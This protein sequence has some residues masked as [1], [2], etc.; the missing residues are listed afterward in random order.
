MPFPTR[1]G[2]LL[3]LGTVASN[4]FASIPI[5]RINAINEQL[6]LGQYQA[7]E[8]AALALLDSQQLATDDVSTL[9][10]LAGRFTTAGLRD[11]AGTLLT[12]AA[13]LLDAPQTSSDRETLL[14]IGASLQALNLRSQ[15][16]GVLSRGIRITGKDSADRLNAAGFQS[17]G[18]LAFET[19]DLEAADSAYTNSE[20]ALQ[21]DDLQARA[22]LVVRQIKLAVARA[23]AAQTMQR[24]KAYQ[25]LLT[26]LTGDLSLARMNLNVAASL[27]A[28]DEPAWAADI[29]LLIEQAAALAATDGQ[30]MSEIEQMRG[31]VAALVGQPDAALVMLRRALAGLGSDAMPAQTYRLYWQIGKLQAEAGEIDA[32]LINYERA[33]ANLDRIR[34]ELLQGS[35]LVFTER[36]LPVYQGY[37]ELLLEKARVPGQ[38]S[39]WLGQVQETLEGLNAA[40]ILD[41]FDDNCV[42]P[43][44]VMSLSNTAAG[45]AVLYPI[46]LGTRPV[47]LVRTANGIFRFDLDVDNAQLKTMALAFREAITNPKTSLAAYQAQA[48]ALFTALLGPAQG[49]IERSSI[50]TL[51]TVPSAYL[52]LVPMAALHDGEDFLVNRYQLATTLGLQLTEN[53]SIDNVNSSAF[54]GGVSDAVQ[55]FVSL[56]GVETELAE[57]KDALSATPLLNRN[58][59]VAN[60]SSRLSSGNDSIVHLATHGYFDGDHANSFLLAHDDKITLD[61]LQSTVGARRFTGNPLDLLVLSACETAKGDERAALGLAGVSLKAG[62]RST[63]ASLW[64]IADAATAMLMKRFY[65]ELRAG[66]SKA[67]ALQSAQQMLLSDPEWAHPNYW[68]PYLLIGNWL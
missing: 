40:E 37:I 30:V 67:A 23:D 62:A 33:I 8:K 15:A 42:L 35:T 6:E 63:V 3:L 68:S 56:P 26:Q 50:T 13:E 34:G 60:V 58:F 49:L 44:D 41:Y 61:R 1:L 11:Q 31:Q 39:K 19:G 25:G 43:R 48:G 17:L 22:A 66:K 16:V 21:A 57:L 54:I 65:E 29:T 28:S 32:A 64:P 45:T 52:R 59:S 46:T 55:G 14:R 4:L 2:L 5:G 7:A 24:Y 12:K 36:V 51:V 9:E 53:A 10:T 38:E 20:S 18:D 27:L 47:L